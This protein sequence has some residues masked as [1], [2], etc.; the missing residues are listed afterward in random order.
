MAY[1]E[2][3][4][5]SGLDNVFDNSYITKSELY[6][7][8]DQLKE[9]TRFYE[10]EV[11]E[12]VEID[13]N[14]A[15]VVGRY[16]FSEQGDSIDEIDGRTFLPLNSNILQYPLRGELW[17]GMSYKGQHYY[18]ARLSENIDNINFEKFNE[19][20]RVPIQTTELYRGRNADGSD[21][22]DI[23]P[24]TPDVSIGDTL[25]QGRFNNYLKIGNTEN[26][27]S[28]E[29]R[30]SDSSLFQMTNE[31]KINLFSENDINIQSVSG[32]VNIQSNDKITLKPTNSTIEFDIKE[33]GNGKIVN[34]TN[35]GV[36]F[37]ELNLAG[38][39]KQINGVKKVFEGLQAGVPL[40]PS[41]FGIKKVVE[42]L[43]GAKD[44]ID[45]TINLEFLDQDVL[46]T[47]TL[48]EL[49]AALPIPEGFG[50]IITDV[51]N[52]TDEQLSKVDKLLEE[53]DKL[54][55]K[56]DEIRSAIN[57]TDEDE[58]R[59]LFNNFDDS[60][61]GVSSIKEAL[62][63]TD[64]DTGWQNFKDM[65]G[66]DEFDE[67]QTKTENTANGAKTIKSYKNLFNR[68]GVN[69]E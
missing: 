40:L 64:S 30:N 15:Q 35:E 9:Q 68:I 18:L 69:N 66:L 57:L 49:Q 16:V 8:L 37:P 32:D 20:S 67:F 48:G 24:I 11:F 44:F 47:R 23:V 29:I 14:P 50:N 1:T 65:G 21:F 46:T 28:I 34:I 58:A 17:L 63:I 61:P 39:M 45:A 12:V 31:K 54:K 3:D 60:I 36:P 41:P 10:L 5:G 59:N 26:T 25:V 7:I 52:I 13:E 2:T 56:N 27:S 53:A 19:S 55:Q 62:S 38:F 6:A 43:K 42:G 33:S 51:T 22:V 4:A